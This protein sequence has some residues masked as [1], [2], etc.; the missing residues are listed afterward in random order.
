M[1]YVLHDAPLLA[2]MAGS[3]LQQV[4]APIRV[5][6]KTRHVAS[7]L[8][9]CCIGG[10]KKADRPHTCSACS[11]KALSLGL[12]SLASTATARAACPARSQDG[13]AMSCNSGSRA[14]VPSRMRGTLAGALPRAATDLASTSGASANC[15]APWPS[16]RFAV[17]CLQHCLQLT[18]HG[19]AVLYGHTQYAHAHAGGTAVLLYGTFPATLLHACGMMHSEHSRLQRLH[20]LP[21]SGILGGSPCVWVEHNCCAM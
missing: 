4:R 9:G 18:W 7:K 19:W 15:T 3:P 5:S 21:V 8:S 1:H 10:G 14:P 20:P 12:P 13:P 11:G 2:H 6:G 17:Q 16:V